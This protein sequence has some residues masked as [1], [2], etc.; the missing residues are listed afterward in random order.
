ML[1]IS[2][3]AA[4][5]SADNEVVSRMLLSCSWSASAGRPSGCHN[6]SLCHYPNRAWCEAWNKVSSLEYI[7]GLIIIYNLEELISISYN[8]DIEYI[9]RWKKV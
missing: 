8:E 7:C 4:S 5:Y 3:E 6:E 1:F 9:R 2:I